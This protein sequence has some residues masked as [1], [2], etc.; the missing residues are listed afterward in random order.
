M[1]GVTVTCIQRKVIK[2]IQRATI[3]GLTTGSSVE[4]RAGVCR[5]CSG[6]SRRPRV[7]WGQDEDILVSLTQGCACMSA[8][9]MGGVFCRRM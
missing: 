8:P 5:E 3:F 7:C 4:R 6:K 9:L 1:T 2:E